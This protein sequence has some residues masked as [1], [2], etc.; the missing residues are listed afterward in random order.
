MIPVEV[1]L[2]FGVNGEA[3]Q[4]KLMETVQGMAPVEKEGDFFVINVQGN[5]I[6]SGII[7]NLWV[8]TNAKGYKDA[9]EG[10]K[11]D[12]SLVD[13]KFND[14]ANPDVPYMYHCHMLVHED[15]AM[16]GQFEVVDKG[17]KV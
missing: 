4:E 10:G 13:S 6:Y 2:G 12:K 9:I 3:I 16:M 5:E 7:D 8:I 1:F 15:D 11:L 17:V 14:F